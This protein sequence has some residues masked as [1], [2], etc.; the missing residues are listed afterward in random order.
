MI[1][2]SHL[3]IQLKEPKT[4]T[5]LALRWLRLHLPMQRVWVPPLTGKLRFRMLPGQNRKQ[6]QNCNK[7]KKDFKNGP[8]QKKKKELKEAESP[9]DIHTSLFLEAL[10]TTAKRLKQLLCPSTDD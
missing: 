4:R 10:F 3:C 7:F 6:K 8:H 9:R 5:P 1:Y 2:K